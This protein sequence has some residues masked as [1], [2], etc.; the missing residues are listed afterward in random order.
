MF[1]IVDYADPYGVLN[2]ECLA[3]VH[4]MVIKKRD[5]SLKKESEQNSQSNSQSRPTTSNPGNNKILDEVKL[6]AVIF[7]GYLFIFFFYRV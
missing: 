2:I 4:D 6:W 7:N 5:L 3:T 1:E